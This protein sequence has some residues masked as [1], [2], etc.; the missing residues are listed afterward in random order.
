MAMGQVPEWRGSY[1][2]ENAKTEITDTLNP[3]TSFL[4][5]YSVC[6]LDHL[7]K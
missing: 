2:E 1:C 7:V 4:V 3:H 6:Q 5:L